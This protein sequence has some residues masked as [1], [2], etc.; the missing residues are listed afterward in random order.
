[1]SYPTV[2]EKLASLKVTPAS[3]YERECMQKV[4]RGAYEIA[5]QRTADILDEGYERFGFLFWGSQ[6]D[7]EDSR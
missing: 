7:R 2:E 3:D 5:V 1:M 6:C 4:S